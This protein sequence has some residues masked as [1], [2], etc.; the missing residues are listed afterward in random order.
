MAWVRGDVIT[1]QR[2]EGRTVRAERRL[3]ARA[4]RLAA[5]AARKQQLAAHADTADEPSRP[6]VPS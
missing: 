4:E 1:A 2:R 6:E 5:R 3:V